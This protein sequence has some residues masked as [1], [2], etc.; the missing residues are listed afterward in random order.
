MCY[1]SFVI[2]ELKDIERWSVFDKTIF[3]MMM[4]GRLIC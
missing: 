2:G 1:H 4:E 3:I